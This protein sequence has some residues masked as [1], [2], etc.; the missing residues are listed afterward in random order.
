[1]QLLRAID[2]DNVSENERETLPLRQ[3]ARAIVLDENK[4]IA[5]L[6][7]Q[8]GNY[9]KIPGGGIEP[10]EDTLVALKRECLEEIGCQVEVD[11]EIGLII[12]YRQKFNVRQ[13]SYCFLAHVIGNKG[14]PSFTEKEQADGFSV[15]WIPLEQAIE[16]I[17]DMETGDYQG[18]F[19]I[20]RELTFLQEADKILR[21]H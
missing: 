7:V 1:M 10:G 21:S 5:L 9:Y 15:I 14:N 12:E 17:K 18:K 8:K 3:A 6:H 13:E 2:L 11:E 4:N 19:V 20:L 16:R